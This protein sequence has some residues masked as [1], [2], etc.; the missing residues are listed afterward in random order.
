MIL[1]CV[2]SS[3]YLYR[4]MQAVRVRGLS[5]RRQLFILLVFPQRIHFTEV[6]QAQMN[7]FKRI[8]IFTIT[9]IHQLW[10]GWLIGNPWTY[11]FFFERKTYHLCTSM[12]GD[13]IQMVL[14]NIG[15][16]DL[17]REMPWTN[18][19]CHHQ[20]LIFFFALTVPDVVWSFEQMSF[21]IK[22][23]LL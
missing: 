6:K 7:L 1:L 5:C 15:V 20:S 14:V 21:R 22:I 8:E 10:V 16:F 4:I 2:W 13:L 12:V 9:L 19:T 3:Q 17:S 11:H 18:P 23:S